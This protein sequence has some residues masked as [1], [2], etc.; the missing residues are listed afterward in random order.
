MLMCVSHLC[1]GTHVKV[2]RQLYVS[3]STLFETALY[4]RL[5]GCELLKD[6]QFPLLIFLPI[7]AMITEVSAITFTWVLKV[8]TW[9]T[10]LGGGSILPTVPCGAAVIRSHC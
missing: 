4:T 7:S 10:R 8:Q 1:H 5:G 6:S 3:P 2:S 9:T